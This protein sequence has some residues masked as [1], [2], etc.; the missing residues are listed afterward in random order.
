MLAARKTNL[1]AAQSKPC[2]VAG[3]APHVPPRR[4]WTWWCQFY[5]PLP[6]NADKSFGAGL[7][8]CRECNGRGFKPKE[9]FCSIPFPSQDFRHSYLSPE[10]GMLSL[11]AR[12]IFRHSTQLWSTPFLQLVA[13]MT[14]LLYFYPNKHMDSPVLLETHFPET[15]ICPVKRSRCSTVWDIP[16]LWAVMVLKWCR[17]NALRGWLLE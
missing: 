12:H 6:E 10:Q 2:F 9:V 14:K 16:S 1:G 5:F 7:R 11:V 4:S 3:S 15:G 8:Y 13:G 17:P